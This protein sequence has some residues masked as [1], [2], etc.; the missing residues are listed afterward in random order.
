MNVFDTRG[1]ALQYSLDAHGRNGIDRSRKFSGNVFPKEIYSEI[2]IRERN[3]I[4]QIR[5]AFLPVNGYTEKK[6]SRWIEES[7]RI[8]PY[9]RTAHICIE[10]YSSLPSFNN[11]VVPS[12]PFNNNKLKG[13][14]IAWQSFNHLFHPR[15]FFF[16][17][18][19]VRF[20]KIR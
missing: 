5:D 3:A 14:E 15:P 8:F 18:R 17:P 10:N 20:L 4:F 12:V 9:S 13:F 2:Y 7:S 1:V 11:N 16:H 6:P 19:F